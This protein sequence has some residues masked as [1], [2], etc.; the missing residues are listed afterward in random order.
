MGLM[1]VNDFADH[2]VALFY[3]NNSKVQKYVWFFPLLQFFNTITYRVFHFF[4]LY[5]QKKSKSD[6]QR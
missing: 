2:F 5:L 4:P 1:D 3:I 6:M